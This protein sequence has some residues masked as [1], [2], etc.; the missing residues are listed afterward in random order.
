[1]ST[2]ARILSDSLVNWDS[3][4]TSF[5]IS[6]T[7]LAVDY[8]INMYQYGALK[9]LVGTARWYAHSD[10]EINNIIMR[11]GTAADDIISVSIKKNGSIVKTAQLSA[12]QTSKV[13]SGPFFSMNAGD[14][15]TIDTTN[16]G[17]TLTGEDLYLQLIYRKV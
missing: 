3:A 5:G 2:K 16:V 9:E 1:M 17:T 4:G 14:Y 7:A 13:I 8:P 6:D 15:L 12:E 10:L 11:V